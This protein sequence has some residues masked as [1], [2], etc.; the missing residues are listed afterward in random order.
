M[1]NGMNLDVID[2]DSLL[3]NNKTLHIKA[4]KLLKYDGN[5]PTRIQDGLTYLFINSKWNFSG[6]FLSPEDPYIDKMMVRLLQKK[7][8][9]IV[10]GY[11]VGM[12]W[13]SDIS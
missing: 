3:Y 5:L 11:I 6:T 10:S 12:I 8:A 7:R 9:Y 2:L 4:M 1:S 13:S